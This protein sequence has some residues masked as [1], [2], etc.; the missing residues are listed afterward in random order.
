MKM[1]NNTSTAKQVLLHTVSF[2]MALAIVFI[3]A[4]VVAD[5]TLFND[6]EL[7]SKVSGT[8]Y[9]SQLNE[10]VVLKIKTIGAKYGVDYRIITDVIT[11]GK[12]DTDMT[13]YF[14]SLKIEDPDS[15]K[16]TIDVKTLEKQL[17]DKFEEN[18]A[19]ITDSQEL[20]LQTIAA[21][22]A[23]EY[24]DA[25]VIEHFEAFLVFAREYRTVSRYVFFGL[26]VFLIY[27]V[28]V[29]FVLNGKQQKHKL[30]RRY[31][32]SFGSAG[33]TII[34]ISL[35]I[36]FTE[37]IE[38]VSFVSSEREYNLFVYVFTDFVKNYSIVGV[39]CVMVAVVLLALW[40]LSV[41]GRTRR[42][43]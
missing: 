7:L 30:L 25:I 3:S 16:D 4:M 10:D 20:S 22:I 40:Y 34:C 6:R 27:L 15:A 42:F 14:N 36:R 29:V 31:S 24:K 41:T 17:I 12:I 32:I 28:C 21:L 39:G 18:N 11:P 9:F 26:L 35:V 2:F 23:E 33:L 38:R 37:I 8:N 13:I 5:I 1:E 19:F 43:I